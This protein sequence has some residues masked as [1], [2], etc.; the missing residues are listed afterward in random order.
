MDNEYRLHYTA[1]SKVVHYTV[2]KHNRKHELQDSENKLSMLI[3]MPSI[4]MCL[5]RDSFVTEVKERNS[6]HSHCAAGNAT[7]A[8]IIDLTKAA[9][10]V[11]D[12]MM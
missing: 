7:Q 1:Y 6:R 10:R 12:G 9:H 5:C 3:V 8:K 4:L 11:L 2:T